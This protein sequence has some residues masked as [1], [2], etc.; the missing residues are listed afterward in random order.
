VPPGVLVPL[1][2]GDDVR[3][4]GELVVAARAAVHRVGHP[5]V[6]DDEAVLDPVDAGW[7]SYRLVVAAQRSEGFRRSLRPPGHAYFL[8]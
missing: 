7:T 8:A 2:P 1:R 6:A 4:P 5:D 3:H